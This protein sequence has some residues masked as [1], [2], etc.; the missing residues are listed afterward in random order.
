MAYYTEEVQPPPVLVFRVASFELG[1][2]ETRLEVLI[3]GYDPK[4]LILE[5]LEP[6]V[7]GAETE[8]LARWKAIK[9]ERQKG[10]QAAEAFWRREIAATLREAKA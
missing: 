7:D 3:R 5:E 4:G 1:D 6:T 2:T 8:R 10:V 9:R